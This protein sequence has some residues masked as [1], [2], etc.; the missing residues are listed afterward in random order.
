[1][2]PAALILF[3]LLPA[4]AFCQA[5]WYAPQRVDLVIPSPG[6]PADMLDS[7]PKLSKLKADEGYSEAPAVK[8]VA[9]V[10]AAALPLPADDL[11]RAG[12]IE[13]LRTDLDY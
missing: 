4:A 5:P 7:C 11:E 9:E 13:V 8:E 2:K 6:Q 10:D 12:I 1:M 3:F